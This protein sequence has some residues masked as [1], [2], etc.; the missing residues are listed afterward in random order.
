MSRLKILLISY[1]FPP[2]G[3]A[4]VSRPLALFKNLPHFDID[5]DILTVKNIS[6]RTYEP[7]LL[8]DLQIGRA[9]CRERV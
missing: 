1:Y 7:E 8:K 3:G 2:L 5:V 4:G 9:S 6:Y